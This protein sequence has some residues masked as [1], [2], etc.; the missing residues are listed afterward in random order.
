[1]RN[2]TLTLVLMVALG[3]SACGRKGPLAPPPGNASQV[4]PNSDVRAV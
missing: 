2:I 4:M 3:L 1:M